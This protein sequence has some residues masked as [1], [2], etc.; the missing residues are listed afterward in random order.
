LGTLEL[1]IFEIRFSEIRVVQNSVLEYRLFEIRSDHDCIS[2]IGSGEIG[3]LEVRT[4]TERPHQSRPTQVRFLQIGPGH[5]SAFEIG[6][7]EEGS[8]QFGFLQMAAFEIR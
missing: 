5:V 4:P 1:C 2:K 6:V 7:T 8:P 3:S